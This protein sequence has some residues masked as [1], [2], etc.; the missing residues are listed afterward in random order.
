[1]FKRV[2]IAAALSVLAIPVSAVQ[3]TAAPVVRFT[4]V[5]YDSPGKD[6]RTNSSLNA[7]WARIHNFSTTRRSL[8]GW[9]V[10]D[11]SGHVYRFGT[12]SLAPGATVTLHTGHG[13]NTATNRYWG[14]GNYIWNNTGDKAILRNQAGSLID[15]CAWTSGGSYKV[16]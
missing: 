8:T 3:A 13:T 10:R 5:Y 12:F 4:K 6:T 16:C 7:E 14:S 2:A 15:S 9:T 1:M 11:A